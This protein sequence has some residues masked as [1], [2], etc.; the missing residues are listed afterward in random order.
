MKITTVG[1]L[2]KALQ[3]YPPDMPVLKADPCGPGY[4]EIVL[5]DKM[6]FRIEAFPIDHPEIP[7]NESI[8]YEDARDAYHGFLAVAL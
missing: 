5:T 8:A 2:I 6:Q 3:Q 7:E 4:F 1:E